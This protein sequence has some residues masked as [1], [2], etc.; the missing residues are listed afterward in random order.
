MSLSDQYSNKYELQ[1]WGFWSKG[2]W[3][4]IWVSSQSFMVETCTSP[5]IVV[6]PVRKCVL[7]PT[8]LQH[9]WGRVLRALLTNSL[10]TN[11]FTKHKCV[12]VN[13]KKALHRRLVNSYLLVFFRRCRCCCTLMNAFGMARS[14]KV[15]AWLMQH[16]N[17]Q[18]FSRHAKVTIWYKKRQMH[19]NTYIWHPQACM[20]KNSCNWNM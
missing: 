20:W 14:F 16:S 5:S 12:P 17:D 11:S 4:W 19:P 13:Q 3:R 2:W 10:N 1:V 8:Q 9:P 7:S 6:Q 18:Y 15:W